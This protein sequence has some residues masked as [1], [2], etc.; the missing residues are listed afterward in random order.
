VL[1]K[2][3]QVPVGHQLAIHGNIIKVPADVST[4]CPAK[5][6]PPLNIFMDMYSA[7]LAFPDNYM[8]SWK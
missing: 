3:N 1:T 5:E 2:I 8:G 7:E 4:L 6:N